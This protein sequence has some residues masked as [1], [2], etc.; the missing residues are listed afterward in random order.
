MNNEV[1]TSKSKLEFNVANL[2]IYVWFLLII[3]FSIIYFIIFVSPDWISTNSN[4][5]LH[6]KIKLIDDENNAYSTRLKKSGHFGLYKYC[7]RLSTVKN[8]LNDFT[9][10]QNSTR[11]YFIKSDVTY[12]KCVGEWNS[13]E[14]FQNVYFGIST[15]LVGLAC[16]L[17]IV[18]VAVCFWIIFCTKIPQ[19]VL[20][21][22]SFIQIANGFYK[23]DYLIFIFL[24]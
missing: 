12:T 13:L 3:L 22:S 14:A 1:N 18:C 2:I 7:I 5:T 23:I 21:L 11:N 8:K 15:C 24:N 17:G 19:V 4:N 20:Y 9:A 16:I 6:S 10:P